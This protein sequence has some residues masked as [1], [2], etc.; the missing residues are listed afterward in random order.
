M[1]EGTQSLVLLCFDVDVPTEGTDVN[2]EGRTVPLDLPRADFFHWV[3]ADL[4]ASLREVT[5]GAHCSAIT[6]KGKAPGPTVD[7]G[8]QGINDYTSWFAADPDM[9]GDYGGY[10]GPCPPWN[11]ER[12]HGY[13]F[14]IYA[15]DV[16]TLGLHGAFTGGDVREAMKGHVLD[17]AE[18]T[19]LYNIFPGAR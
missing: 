13:R 15:L 14:A 7:G 2:Q 8:L 5:E 19:G 16:Q 11:D 6:A 3:T 9:A 12:V 1:P 4:P 10:D 18:M 17:S